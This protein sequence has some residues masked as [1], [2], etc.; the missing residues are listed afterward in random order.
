MIVGLP[1]ARSLVLRPFGTRGDHRLV[2]V[3]LEPN[4]DS[5][6]VA[7]VFHREFPILDVGVDAI[8]K[9]VHLVHDLVHFFIVPRHGLGGRFD[10]G[11]WRHGRGPP[12]FPRRRWGRSRATSARRGIV[13]LAS[14]TGSGAVIVSAR[15]RTYPVPGR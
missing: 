9:A 13:G 10:R 14:V 11:F 3:D 5:R 1:P 2:D 6:A 8:E 7:V 15:L 4:E 12:A